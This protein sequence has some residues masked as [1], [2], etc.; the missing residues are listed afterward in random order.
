MAHRFAT[1]RLCTALPV[2][3]VISLAVVVSPGVKAEPAPLQGK[4][5][6]ATF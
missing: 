6:R 3:A 5:R 1:R 2:A 4:T